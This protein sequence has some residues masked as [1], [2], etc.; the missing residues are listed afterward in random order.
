M[1]MKRCP[2][3]GERYSD[4]YRNCPFCEEEEYWEE[5]EPRRSGRGGRGHGRQY[6]LITPTLIVLIILMA[7]L[8][9]YLLYGE[10]IAQR[11]A[12]DPDEGKN[13][14]TTPVEP[15]PGVTGPSV[16]DS[17][18]TTPEGSSGTGQEPAGSGTDSTLEPSDTTPD[19]T[20][21]E[22]PGGNQGGGTSGGGTSSS[23]GASGGMSYASAAA[24]PSG[25]TLSSTD[26]SRSVSEGSHRLRVSGG[27]GTYTWISEDPGIA[28]VASDGTVTP[29]GSGMT[30]ILVTDGSKKGV[31]IVRV[32]GGSS[33]SG[34]SGNS[35]GGSGGSGQ[36]NK[37]DFTRATSEGAYQLK[38]SGVTTAITWSSSNTA[39]A[40]VDGS[41]N[42]T[43]V[44][45][46]QATITASWDGR[47]L[48]CIIRV[49]R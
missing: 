12:K 49:P 19:G 23:D 24:L 18:T 42:V 5:E 9:I 21:P 35:G 6:N 16:P 29:V 10:R 32:R 30:H 38:V 25:L 8:L 45:V 36:L 27:T 46:G 34:S 41:G 14:I 4:T 40:T 43:P 17:G 31:C 1:A 39:V 37:T 33:S 11:F 28:T 13:D 15:T 2:V 7:A 26:F 47:S 3:C 44:G 48:S 20:M 22:G